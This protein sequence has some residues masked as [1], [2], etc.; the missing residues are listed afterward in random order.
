MKH[1]N[2]LTLLLISILFLISCEKNPSEII[3]LASLKIVNTVTSGY[4][5][6]LGSYS[7]VVNNNA[8]ADFVLRPGNPE[9]YV[10]PATDSLHPYY[11]NSK[12]TTVNEGEISTLFL[13]GDTISPEGIMVKE[14][15]PVRIDSVAGV[16]FINLSP[17]SPAVKVV[18]S[19]SNTVSEFGDI[20][21]KQL[22]DFKSY[23]ALSTNT[24]Y[25]FEVRDAATDILITSI[26][27]SGTSLTSFVPRFRNVTLVLRGIVAGSPSAGIT[28]VNHYQ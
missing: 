13:T 10:Y 20:A 28:R 7:T 25:K 15:L 26:T 14:N 16:R 18:L 22:T 21:Y 5:V 8:H 17:G 27:M 4:P 1:V 2:Q 9:I 6:K 3:P 12:S 19:T 11:N 24:S 23:P